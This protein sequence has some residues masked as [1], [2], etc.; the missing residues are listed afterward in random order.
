MA[1]VHDEIIIVAKTFWTSIYATFG[2]TFDDK[3]SPGA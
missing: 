3:D 2:A 1:M